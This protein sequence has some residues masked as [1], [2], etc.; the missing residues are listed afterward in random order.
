[1]A[2]AM[3]TVR[4][5]GLVLNFSSG[6]PGFKKIRGAASAIEYTAVYTRHL[7]PER[8]AV[9]TLLHKTSHAYYKKILLKYGL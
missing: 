4:E 2:Q 6:A 3:Q 9:W 5:M 1:M 7:P 8:R